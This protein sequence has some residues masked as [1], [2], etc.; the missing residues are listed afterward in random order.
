MDRDRR[1]DPRAARPARRRAPAGRRDPHHDP[2]ARPGS[3]RAV[4][5]ATPPPGTAC[6]PSAQPGRRPLYRRGHAQAWT[7]GTARGKSEAVTQLAPLIRAIGDPV[8]RAHYMQKVATL[9]QSPLPIIEHAVARARSRRAQRPPAAREPP[10]RRSPPGSRPPPPPRDLH[11]PKSICWPCCCAI[12][13]RRCYPKRRRRPLHAQ[14]EPPDRRDA[15]RRSGRPA[16]GDGLAAVWSTGGPCARLDP[17]LQEHFDTLLAHA[18]SRAAHLPLQAGRASCKRRVR[19]LSEYDDRIWVQQCELLL[20]DARSSG[21]QETIAQ[22]A[23]V[24]EQIRPQL[25]E[26]TPPHAALSSAI[27]GIRNPIGR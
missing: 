14:R 10:S 16:A 3:R 24:L 1:A 20:A 26:P 19:R 5:A 15:D 13:R 17:A 9:T 27:A 22:L 8:E 6:W 12:R 25:M 18:D 11:R 21:D 2:A 4:A 7:C 23:R